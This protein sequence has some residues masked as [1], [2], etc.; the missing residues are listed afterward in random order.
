MTEVD[1]PNS[2]RHWAYLV[3]KYAFEY[4]V[5]K[6]VFLICYSSLP[7]CTE[8]MF[9]AGADS[10]GQSYLSFHHP[11]AQLNLIRNLLFGRW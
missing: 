8:D 6:E 4:I 5:I 10:T 1:T 9:L 2:G 11:C 7:L 3:L